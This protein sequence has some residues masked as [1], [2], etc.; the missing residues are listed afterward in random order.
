MLEYG[1]TYLEENERILD[2][3]YAHMSPEGRQLA[4]QMADEDLEDIES[5]VADLEAA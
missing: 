1:V 3:M 4:E 2:D 5:E